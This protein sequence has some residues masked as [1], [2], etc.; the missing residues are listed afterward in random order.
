SERIK[1]LPILKIIISLI[2]VLAVI[3]HT[4]VVS[5][6]KFRHGPDPEVT[7]DKDDGSYDEPPIENNQDGEATPDTDLSDGNR[8]TRYSHSNTYWGSYGSSCDSNLT[9]RKER[10]GITGATSCRELGTTALPHMVSITK[11][12]PVLNPVVT[13]DTSTNGAGIK[14]AVGGTALR[15]PTYV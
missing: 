13:K 6:R 2:T 5:G 14:V 4:Y 12:F 9:V 15:L 10:T 7:R 3:F 8:E 1:G 11:D